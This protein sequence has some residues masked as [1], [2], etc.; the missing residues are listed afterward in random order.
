VQ[1]KIP[2]LIVAG[3]ASDASADSHD[4]LTVGR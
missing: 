3:T 2:G 4:L 1:L